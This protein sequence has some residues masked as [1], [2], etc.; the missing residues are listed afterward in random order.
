MLA[1][2][3]G[4]VHADPTPKKIFTPKLAVKPSPKPPIST[5]I[6]SK[7]PPK[8]KPSYMEQLQPPTSRPS[9]RPLSYMELLRQGAYPQRVEAADAMMQATAAT[10]AHAVTDTPLYAPLAALLAH[11]LASGR[12]RISGQEIFWR[13]RLDPN[14]QRAE[15]RA[16]ARV[17]RALG[18]VKIHYGKNGG[19]RV[20]GW[21]WREWNV[22]QVKIDLKS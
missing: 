4:L 15:G 21:R 20:W 7:I 6:G 12:D 22:S 1:L 13:L 9:T 19:H 11:T 5:P 2:L 17:L 16:I 8:P 18:W 14:Q 3:S 10:H